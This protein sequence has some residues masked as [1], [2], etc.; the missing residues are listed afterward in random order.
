MPLSPNPIVN[1]LII[2]FTFVT[3]L[4]ACVSVYRT[5]RRR[6]YSSMRVSI[7]WAAGLGVW[8]LS[9]Y[10]YSLSV[11]KQEGGAVISNAAIFWLNALG[12]VLIVAATFLSLLT[13][14]IKQTKKPD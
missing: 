13:S 1:M 4:L 7:L 3:F 9:P 5:S 8:L 14:S 6:E 10:Y 12:F 2:A 11:V